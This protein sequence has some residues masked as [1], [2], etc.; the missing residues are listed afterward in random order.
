MVTEREAFIGIQGLPG[1]CPK[2]QTQ[3][4]GTERCENCGF[5]EL[6]DPHWPYERWCPVCESEAKKYGEPV[7]APLDLYNFRCKACGHEF[8]A[9]YHEKVN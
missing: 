4:F 8:V 6:D 9:E 5:Q 3:R 1:P 2:C 7:Y